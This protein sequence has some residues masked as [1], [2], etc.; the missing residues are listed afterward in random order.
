MPYGFGDGMRARLDGR[1]NEAILHQ[2]EA[3]PPHLCRMF[4]G[5]LVRSNGNS[6][7]C[8]FTGTE[9]GT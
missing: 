6:C 4:A 3:R 1:L 2:M 7:S 5:A 9:V 8:H